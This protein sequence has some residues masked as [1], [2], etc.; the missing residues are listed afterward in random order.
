MVFTQ[1]GEAFNGPG[2]CNLGCT[3]QIGASPLLVGQ[4]S[5]QRT[6]FL[7]S[8][9]TVGGYF[10]SEGVRVWT[11]QWMSLVLFRNIPHALSQE[12]QT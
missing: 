5:L 11:P 6:Y 3:R 1:A 8:K 4:L 12:N 7:R 10:R 2:P 9:I